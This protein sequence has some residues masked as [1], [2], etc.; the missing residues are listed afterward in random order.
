MTLHVLIYTDKMMG[1]ARGNAALFLIR[2]RPEYKDDKGLFMHELTHVKQAWRG[3][4]IFH[5]LRIAFSKKYR[6]KCE[7][8][9][10]TV[11]VKCYDKENRDYYI[12]ALAKHL[13]S[14]YNLGI[15]VDKAEYDIRA[16]L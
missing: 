8:E 3:F 12:S 11:Q 5:A 14:K 10:Y 9:A 6:Y 7:I 1:K 15:S 13:V 16:G 2:I 4:L